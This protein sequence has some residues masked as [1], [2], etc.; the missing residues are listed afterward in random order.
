VS[1]WKQAFKGWELS[2]DGWFNNRRGE[3]WLLAQL[4]LIS[5]HL[6]PAWPKPQVFGVDWPRAVQ[7]MGLTTLVLGVVLAVQG[8]LALG[9]SLSPLPD[10][11]PGAVLVT[12]GVYGHCRHP[13]Y[14]AV[15]V[16][17]LGV[18]FALGSLLHLLL[19]LVLAGVLVGKAKREERALLGQL[20][21]YADYMDRTA[22]IVGRCPGLDWRR[23]EAS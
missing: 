3:W 21:S 18:V 23:L 16:C 6:A 9:P 4:A 19:L 12:T 1:E 20:P 5:C 11:K 15:L 2:W 10:P 22:A 7:L 14:R 8:F 13:L 17:S